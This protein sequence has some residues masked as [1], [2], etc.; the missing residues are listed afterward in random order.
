MVV[1]GTADG[2]DTALADAGIATLAVEA[3]HIARTVVVDDALGVAAGRGSVAHPAL[4]VAR[5]WTW[6]A[7]VSF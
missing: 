1:D 2:V 4:A 3:G 5:A 7:R 6:I